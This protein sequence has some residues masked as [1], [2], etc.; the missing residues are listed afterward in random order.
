MSIETEA[1]SRLKK[2]RVD[3]RE[4]IKNLSHI[5]VEE[6]EG[7]SSYTR[8]YLDTLQESLDYLIDIRKR[9]D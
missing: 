9:I 3:I 1:S 6:C 5:V 2:V 8:R 4:V 7:S